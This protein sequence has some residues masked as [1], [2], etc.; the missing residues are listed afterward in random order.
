MDAIAGGVAH[1]VPTTPTAAARAAGA[2]FQ[3]QAARYAASRQRLWRRLLT[4]VP[5]HFL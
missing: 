5:S 4:L 1:R 3:R 2:G